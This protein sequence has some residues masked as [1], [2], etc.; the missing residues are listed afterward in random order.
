MQVIK[1]VIFKTYVDYNKI[2]INSMK[3]MLL[4]FLLIFVASWNSQPLHLE[5]DRV[6]MNSEKLRTPH[7]ESGIYFN[8]F[9]EP[10]LNTLRTPELKILSEMVNVLVLQRCLFLFLKTFFEIILHLLNIWENRPKSGKF[11]KYQYSTT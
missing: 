10:I 9:L 2:V 3:K 11:S 5:P 1:S 6:W 4:R 8:Q 7:A